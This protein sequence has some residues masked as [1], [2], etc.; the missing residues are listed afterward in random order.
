MVNLLKAQLQIAATSNTVW[1]GVTTVGDRIFVCFPR[2]EGDSGMRIG[3]VLPGG[4]IVPY[5][6][7]AW[8]NWRP[9][10]NV[11]NTFIRANSLRIGPDGLLWVVDTGTPALG[12]APLPGNAAKLVAIDPH[13]NKV[14][15]TVPLAGVSRKN[16]FIDDLRMYGNTIYLT[17]AGEPALVVM[18]K[19]TGKGRR[20][21]ENH[22]S[23]T[24]EIAIR[25]EGKIMTD[26]KGH[27]IRIHADQLEVSPD[28][29]WLY[30]QPASGPLW[31]VETHYLQDTGIDEK[32]L[33]QQVSLFYKTPSTGG[34][35]ID[36]DGNLYVS[37]VDQQQIIRISPEGKAETILKD[38]RLAWC[39][40]LWMDE[41]GYLWLPA[42]QLN[43]LAA[44]Q[45]GISKLQLPVVIYKIK[46]GARP[47][48]S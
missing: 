22:T 1:N 28:G 47:F 43:R 42:G 19:T 13:T 5:P 9:G 8:N 7:A 21:L 29:R 17:D 30:Y 45:Q 46:T 33:A 6:N 10:N 20:V 18:N 25:A 26:N 48:K 23:T 11:D 16:T 37:D 24:D 2:L 31:R 12:E 35:A 40:A 39:D 44:F 4:N 41:K 34:T 27:E 38:P 15:R 14:V 36:A 32:S 3:E